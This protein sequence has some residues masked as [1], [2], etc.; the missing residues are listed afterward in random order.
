MILEFVN[1]YDIGAKLFPK[2]DSII[3]VESIITV[4]GRDG[5]GT[6]PVLVKTDGL[7]YT[8]RRSANRWVEFIIPRKYEPAFDDCLLDFVVAEIGATLMDKVFPACEINLGELDICF[9]IS[10]PC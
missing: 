8:K 4:L 6:T 9:H 3:V 2:Y 1:E 5:V 7:E 10:T